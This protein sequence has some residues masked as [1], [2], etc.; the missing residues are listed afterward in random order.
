MNIKNIEMIIWVSN[1]FM[2]N[3]LIQKKIESSLNA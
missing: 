1:S 2:N 3:G